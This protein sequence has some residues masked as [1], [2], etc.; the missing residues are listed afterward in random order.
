ML[1]QT[2]NRV[3]S[4]DDGDF[5]E[6]AEDNFENDLRWNGRQIRNDIQSA[7]A[8]AEHEVTREGTY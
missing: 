6:Y 3:G 7:A 1:F 8:L 2:T 4:F 5:L